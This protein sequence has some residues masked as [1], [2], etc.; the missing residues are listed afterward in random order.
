M[1]CPRR[2][3][4]QTSR[5]VPERA[6]ARGQHG[7][8]SNWRRAWLIEHGITEAMRLREGDRV[9]RGRSEVGDAYPGGGHCGKSGLGSEC[10]VPIVAAVRT[11]AGHAV[12]RTCES[13]R[14]RSRR[15]TL[16]LVSL[17]ER[18]LRTAEVSR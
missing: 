7:N 3:V 6:C 17:P 15:P 8:L 4:E 2:F 18:R 14:T 12:V 16:L 5:A 13:S 10:E 11:A 1:V 9:R